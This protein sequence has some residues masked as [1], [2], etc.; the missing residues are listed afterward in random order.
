MTEVTL[1]GNTDSRDLTNPFPDTATYAS[2]IVPDRMGETAAEPAAPAAKPASADGRP[3]WLPAKFKTPEELAASYTALEMR[4]GAQPAGAPPAAGTAPA[5][6][7]PAPTPAPAVLSDADFTRYSQAVVTNGELAP[8]HY[9]ELASKGIPKHVVDDYVNGQK[10]VADSLVRSAYDEAGGKDQYVALAEWA[11]TGL[12]PEV[13]K[14]VKSQFA[15]NDR[16]QILAAVK[17]MKAMHASSG[18]TMAP[19]GGAKG[20]P[21]SVGG[22]PP[23]R[24][25]AEVVAD[26]RTSN[27][28]NDP[29]FRA[30][31]A[32]RLEASNL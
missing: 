17:T 24:S 7:T 21:A 31:V 12:S 15:S 23:Y 27:Y 26:M 14:Q 25:T 29:N 32:K 10:A 28:K 11:R 2:D 16:D 18:A 22:I 13:A 5:P 1:Q 8:E 4:L 3:A 6:G 20:S 30:Y 9:A 19:S